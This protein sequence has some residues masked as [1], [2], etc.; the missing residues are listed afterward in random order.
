MT[1]AVFG[2]TWSQDL[3]E[4]LRSRQEFRSAAARWEGIVILAMTG[5]PSDEV[6][7]VYLDLWHG[8][9][10]E[11]RAG[12]AADNASARLVFSATALAWQQLFGGKLPPLQ[13]LLTGKLTLTK[14]NI[15]ELAPFAGLAG[16]LVDAAASVP[17]IFPA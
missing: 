4:Q 10:R 5:L 12:T 14:G 2:T 17:A 11:A 7:R 3:A 13:A 1:Q 6:R 16:Q 15:M 8:D 9:C